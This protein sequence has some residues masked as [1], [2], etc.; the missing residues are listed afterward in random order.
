MEDWSKKLIFH[1]GFHKKFMKNSKT[2]QN[3]F[4]FSPNPRSLAPWFSI[5]LHL[6]Y[7]TETSLMNRSGP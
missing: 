6:K 1:A 5:Y 3:I 7:D 2:F 4:I